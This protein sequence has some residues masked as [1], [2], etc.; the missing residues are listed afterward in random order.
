[1]KDVEELANTAFTDPSIYIKDELLEPLIEFVKDLCK[2][3]Y[4][5]KNKFQKKV[6]EL[7]RKYH[8]N[9]RNCQISYMYELLFNQKTVFNTQIKK[10]S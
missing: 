1:M 3:N 8:I 7:K 5:S 10:Y 4:C 6:R 2:E 9:P